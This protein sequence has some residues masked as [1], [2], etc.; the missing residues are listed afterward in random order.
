MILGNLKL[1][2][3]KVVGPKLKNNAIIFSEVD[4]IKDLPIGYVDTQ[5]PGKY[6]VKKS[7]ESFFS[8]VNGPFSLKNFLY[9]SE[10]DLLKVE[11]KG[12]KIHVLPN[13]NFAEKRAFIGIRSCDLSALKVLDKTL[14]GYEY[15]DE[16]YK[17]LRNGIFILGVNCVRAGENC[18]CAS[19]NTGPK[20]G[21]GFDLALTEMEDGFLLEV[22]SAEGEKMLD[23]VELRR[24]SEYEVHKAGEL[25]ERASKA[26]TKKV[27]TLNL[28]NVLYNQLT[29][30]RW[31]DVAK[32]CL[33]CGNCTMVCPTCF[34][35][36]VFDDNDVKSGVTTRKRIWDSC[37]NVEFAETTA[38]NVRPTIKD[39]YRQWLMHKMA[40][41]VDQFGTF[42]CVGCGRCITWCPV[43]IDITE[44]VRAL[45]GE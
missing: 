6:E 42:G 12:N 45:R 4:S 36:D 25:I 3:Y 28:K 31:N 7:G 38:G 23:G 43:G 8:Y 40:Y 19:M 22:G 14:L 21:D 29:N 35:N 32:R 37:F 27:N 2:G 24:A 15:I 10:V 17:L 41:W 11:K 5:G 13:T 16:R 26:M 18:F 39:R 20:L 44:E 30:Q 1:K 33:S 34:C 9:P